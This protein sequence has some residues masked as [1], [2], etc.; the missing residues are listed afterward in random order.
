MSI[1]AGEC[2]LRSRVAGDT[3]EPDFFTRG[4]RPLRVQAA[5]NDELRQ[6]GLLDPRA[7]R[8]QSYAARF[9]QELV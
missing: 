3:P 8:L 7:D 5:I 1:D 6:A 4:Q 9:A 2:G